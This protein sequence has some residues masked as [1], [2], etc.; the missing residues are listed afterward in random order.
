MK[1]VKG[2]VQGFKHYP[3]VKRKCVKSP[4]HHIYGKSKSK[5][6]MIEL[7]KKKN[8]KREQCELK[9]IKC[10]NIMKDAFMNDHMVDDK[11]LN[12]N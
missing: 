3:S 1:R 12:K 11:K 7:N 6:M 8:I 5:C 9:R 2:Q 10:I 4:Q